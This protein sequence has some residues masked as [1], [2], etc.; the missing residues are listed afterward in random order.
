M[1]TSYY[2]ESWTLLGAVGSRED[3]IVE[4]VMIWPLSVF[5]Q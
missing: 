3:G 5:K 4:S 2:P 1:L